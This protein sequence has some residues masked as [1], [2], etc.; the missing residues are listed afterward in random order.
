MNR[1]THTSTVEELGVG[2]GNRWNQ[3]W[4]FAMLGFFEKVS[5]L[6]ERL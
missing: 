2:V 5:P 4:V 1:Q 6:L 3:P